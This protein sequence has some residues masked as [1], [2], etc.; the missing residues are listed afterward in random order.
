VQEEVSQENF[1]RTSDAI[2][3]QC[4]RKISDDK[5]ANPK[6]VA[7]FQLIKS[8]TLATILPLVVEILM[9][10]ITVLEHANKSMVELL[11]ELMKALSED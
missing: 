2:E 6:R 3:D 8:V 11:A 10:R 7:T 5:D 1:A 9:R 4:H